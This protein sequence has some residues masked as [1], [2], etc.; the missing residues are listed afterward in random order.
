MAFWILNQWASGPLDYATLGFI[1][2]P[3]DVL[4]AA[5]APDARWSTTPAGP[6]TV[7]RYA[8][9]DDPSFIEPPDGRVLAYSSTDNAYVPTELV[10]VP[11]FGE[12]DAI[13]RPTAAGWPTSNYGASGSTLDQV[14]FGPGEHWT[15][16]L[17]AELGGGAVTSYGSNGRRALDV[18]VTLLSGVP[19]SGQTNMVA[20]GRWPGTAARSGLVVHDAIGNDAMNQ[21]AMNAASITVVAI[22]GTAYLDYLRQHYRAALALM[23]TETRAEGHTH[24]ATGGAGWQHAVAAPWAS[25]GEFCYTTAAG[26]WVEYSVTPPQRGPLAGKV[27]VVLASDIPTGSAYAP[28]TISVD[29]GAA[30]A[31]V[32]THR[33]AYVG[34]NGAQ[35]KGV[36]NAIPVTVPV[37]GAAHT[38]R[39]AHAGAAGAALPLDCVLIPSEDPNPIL[40][41]GLEHRLGT[42]PNGFD[43]TDLALFTAN[44]GKLTPVYK[45]VIAEF[46]NAVYVP[47]TVTPNG[48]YSG[49]QVHLN[50][51]GNLQ[52]KNDA[53]AVVRAL[54]PRLDSRVAALRPDSDFTVL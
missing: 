16:L 36:V 39:I 51:R 47:S 13:A 6:E 21:A 27:F 43:A 12:L 34:H 41:M 52:R 30:S 45:E 4:E 54:K 33:A 44:I 31:A 3:G 22:T 38:V 1:A 19:M 23:S 10:D 32:T 11:A 24:S 42:H 35:V 50:S 18:A 26:D 25:G 14:F 20:A 17:A 48:L 8:T 2:W 37:D 40:C 46:G 5:A 49:D 28:V 53:A 15:Q 7:T 9:G 29:G